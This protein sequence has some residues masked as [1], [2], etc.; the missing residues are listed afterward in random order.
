[1]KQMPAEILNGYPLPSNP[2]LLLCLV[3]NK[4]IKPE[5]LGT[6]NTNEVDLIWNPTLQSYLALTYGIGSLVAN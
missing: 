1:M 2:G 6:L 4:L 5:Q 3:E